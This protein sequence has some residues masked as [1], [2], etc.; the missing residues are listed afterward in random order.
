MKKKLLALG[1]LAGSSLFAETR[2]SIG[3]NLGGGYYQPAPVYA[4]P[5][6]PGPDFVWVD[7]YWGPGRVWVP[8][9]WNHRPAYVGRR[10]DHDYYRDHDRGERRDFDR[11]RSGYRGR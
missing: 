1:L 6:Y 3:V 8:G 10:Y 4:V 2:F 5:A 7:G 11:Y 9:Y